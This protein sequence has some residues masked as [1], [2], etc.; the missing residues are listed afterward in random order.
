M[1]QNSKI[2]LCIKGLK[3]R[4]QLFEILID[5]NCNVIIFDYSIDNIIDYLKDN[6]PDLI[7]ADLP[8]IN[9]VLSLKK[10]EN[11]AKY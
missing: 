5:T 6:L 4:E 2:L 10:N 1:I 11:P 7:I 3:E 8:S 9:L